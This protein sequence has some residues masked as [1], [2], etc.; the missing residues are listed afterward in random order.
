[1]QI[2]HTLPVKDHAQAAPVAAARVQ[3]AQVQFLSAG[4]DRPR[5]R[6]SADM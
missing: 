1:V 4:D 3:R 6:P 2:A 5:R